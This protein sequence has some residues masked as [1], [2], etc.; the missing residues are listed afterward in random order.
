MTFNQNENITGLIYYY[1]G[2]ARC[3]QFLLA[4]KIVGAMAIQK[5]LVKKDVGSW[6]PIATSIQLVQSRKNYHTSMRS[7]TDMVMPVRIWQYCVY[8]Y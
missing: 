1:Y 6:G 7:H 3:D 2:F 4:A 5:Y 8:G